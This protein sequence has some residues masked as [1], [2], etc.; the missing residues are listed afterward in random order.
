[1]WYDA[2]VKE[3]VIVK[4]GREKSLALRHPW[5]LSGAIDGVR[6]N[7][8]TGALVR[9]ADR[10]GN[11]LGWGFYNP[12][13]TIPVRLV[14]WGNAPLQAD[15]WKRA[16]RRAIK[17]R[18][19]L[20]RDPDLTA[21]RLVYSESDGLPGLIVDRYGDFLVLQT[22]NP[23]MEELKA[24]IAE[25]LMETLPAR[26]IVEKNDGQSRRREGLPQRVG[27]LIGEPPPESIEILENGLRFLVDP[28]RGQKTGFYLDQRENRDLAARYAG[29][30][31][32]LDA[33]S[34]T[35]GFSVYCARAGAA[36]LIRADASRDALAR[37]Q[38]NLSLNG[39]SRVP[40]NPI[41]DNVFQLL[42]TFRDA[43]RRFDMII[44]DPPKLAATVAQREKAARGYKDINLLAL[45]LL[46]PGGILVT[47]SCSGGIDA[48]AFERILSW[49]AKD[50]RRTVQVLHRLHQGPDHPVR[51]SF[52]EAAYLKGLLCRVW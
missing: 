10:K 48:A 39:L 47:F 31:K 22:L 49:A 42:R 3:T 43:G 30:K 38:R 7:P 28:L 26:G 51:L 32:V 40:D 6:G 35:G 46:S 23:G 36:A 12:A 50:A 17:G 2:A 27:L 41:R 8:G 5:I 19:L 33:F 11:T 1:M 29:G 4:A 16:L 45:K 37:G 25:F 44:L 24:A 34:Y 52:P 21:Y 18:E 15:F 14:A 13:S 9:V 20:E